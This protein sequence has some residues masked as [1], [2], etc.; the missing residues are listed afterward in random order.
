VSDKTISKK[1]ATIIMDMLSTGS[2]DAGM[3]V[4]RIIDLCLRSGYTK[5]APLPPPAPDL[6]DAGGGASASS[7]TS[8]AGSS[9][10]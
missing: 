5:S 6:S 4:G 7:S 8:R 3:R 2:T 10:N 9:A 1:D